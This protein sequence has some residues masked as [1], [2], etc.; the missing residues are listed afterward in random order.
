MVLESEIG[1][2][3]LELDPRVIVR[4]LLAGTIVTAQLEK[5]G[6]KTRTNLEN[7]SST[8]AADGAGSPRPCPLG[9]SLLSFRRLDCSTR[10]RSL[11]EIFVRSRFRFRGGGIVRSHDLSA[12]LFFDLPSSA[13][14]GEE[15]GLLDDVAEM[16]NLLFE[17][18]E[19]LINE[20]ELV[21]EGG[22]VLG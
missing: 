18:C 22:G 9:D 5:Y 3:L 16:L 2:E 20:G 19:S 21:V 6:M 14:F 12:S 10:S 7:G 8:A 1:G 11:V 15:N 13:S 4:S 17:G